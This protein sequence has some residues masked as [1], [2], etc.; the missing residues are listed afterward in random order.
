MLIILLVVTAVLALIHMYYFLGKSG[1]V[2]YIYFITLLIVM[3]LNSHNTDYVAYESMYQR[4]SE[5]SSFLEAMQVHSDKGYMFINWIASLVGLNFIEFRFVIFT[6]SISAIFIMVK[7]LNVP[8]CIIYL[9]YVM[10]PMFMD[11]I[12]IRNFII[13]I[14][15]LFSAYCYAHAETK[16]HVI[17][18]VALMISV[19]VHPFA[20][21]FTPFI[22]FYK[23]Y[24]SKKFRMVTYIPIGLGVLSIAIKMLI[25]TYWNEVTAV[26][27]VM[28][29]WASRGHA[30]VGHQ[31]LTSRQFKIYL[32]V[33]IFTWMLYKAKNYLSNLE[34]VTEIQ[35]KF[36]K[37]SFVAYLYLLC[38]TPFFALDINLATRM[39]RD[40]FLLAYISLGIY[41]QQCKMKRGK[42]GIIIGMLFLA[43]FFG[44]VDLYISNLRFNVDVIVKNNFLL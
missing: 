5:A 8:V 19:T 28:A 42:W 3:G 7:K 10:Y 2:D 29:D 14:V 12:Q 18:F 33:V 41:V 35:K 44:L 31:V 17:G 30:Y 36:V 16:W 20:L 15:F 27:T 1:L 39:P 11:V 25:D 38:W 23:I 37:I 43:F 13:S 9:A 34:S 4:V 40:F 32:V 24:N 22:V 6:L 26:L 21:I